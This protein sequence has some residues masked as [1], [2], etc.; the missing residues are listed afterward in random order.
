[1][2]QQNDET[3]NIIFTFGEMSVKLILNGE[4]KS[5]FLMQIPLHCALKIGAFKIGTP[6]KRF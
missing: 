6:K 5:N 1:M 2:K 4:R 3:R